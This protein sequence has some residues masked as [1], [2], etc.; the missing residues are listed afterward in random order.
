LA[1]VLPATAAPAQTPETPTPLPKPAVVATLNGK[2]LTEAEFLRRCERTVG[3]RADT[4]VGYAV[5]RDWLE[6]SIAEEE[7]ERRKVVPTKEAIDR[8]LTAV[9]RQ[10]E[11]RGE[12]FEDWL[13]RHGRTLVT[14]REDIRQQLV[15]ENLLTEGVVVSDAEVALY[16]ANNKAVFALPEQLRVSRI[17]TGNRDRAREIDAALKQ[18]RPFEDLARKHS[19]DAYAGAGGR[20]AAL[21]DADPKAQGPLE[22]EVLEK[23]MRL[24]SG[25]VAGPIKLDDYWVFVRVEGRLPARTPDLA[26]VQDLLTANLKVQKAGPERLK[27][28]Q[29]RLDQLQREAKV[30]IFRPEYRRLLRAFRRED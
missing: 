9:R 17:T 1:A 19:E 13:A 21:V 29:A 5:L 6:Q 26:D 15:A 4:A 3:G 18:G 22:K 12:D 2:D 16:Y 28:A 30:E 10:F 20:V 27:T 11:F 7:A 8:R 14:M 23:A 24:E 25:K